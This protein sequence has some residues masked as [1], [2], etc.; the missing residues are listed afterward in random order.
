M[1][2]RITVAAVDDHPMF[3][4][5]LRRAVTQEPGISLVAEGYSASDAC[6]IAEQIKPQILLLDIGIPGGGLQAARTIAAR[7]PTV[8]VVMLTASDSDEHVAEA[9]AAGAKGY[10][11][12]G[13]GASEVIEAVRSVHGGTPYISTAV[14]SRLL[15]Q[16]VAAERS[17]QP[18]QRSNYLPRSLLNVR[19][20]QIF[21][22]ASQG[23]TNKEIADKLGL[24]VRTVKRQMSIILQKLQV[25]SRLAAAVSK[26]KDA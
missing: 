17:H 26:I 20:Q 23:L 21:D 19:E 9:V 7:A 22:C 12:K 18:G 11:V 6:R 13:A 8:Q 14:A 2:E 1:D 3:L 5:G 16:K 10:L 24:T 25:R 4:E 15:I